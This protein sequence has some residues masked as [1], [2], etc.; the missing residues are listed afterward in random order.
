MESNFCFILVTCSNAFKANTE[1]YLYDIF[2]NL[3][4]NAC[5][6]SGFNSTDIL[7]FAGSVKIK[8]CCH[9]SLL[10]HYAYDHYMS[11][12]Y[13]T[14]NIVKVCFIDKLMRIQDYDKSMIPSKI[15]R[16]FF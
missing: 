4:L 12:C 8:N 1:L 10:V 16:G 3:M 7:N 6:S 13:D 5:N 2:G 14:N 11:H 15:A 9:L